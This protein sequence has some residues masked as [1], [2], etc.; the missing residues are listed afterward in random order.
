MKMSGVKKGNNLQVRA[1]CQCP[2]TRARVA[3]DILS[4]RVL[5]V[6][7]RDENQRSVNVPKLR[8][9]RHLICRVKKNVRTQAWHAVYIKG[10]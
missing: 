1:I 6:D 8:Q 9:G 4:Q 5:T 7:Y 3:G 10:L 2:L